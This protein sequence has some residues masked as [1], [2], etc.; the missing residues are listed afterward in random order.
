MVKRVTT[1]VLVEVRPTS[2]EARWVLADE[3]T[4]G[5]IVVAGAV[6]LQPVFVV[7]ASGVLEGVGAGGAFGGC[8]AE[9]VVG[10][11]GF[12]FPG[13]FTKSDSALLE[14]G[15]EVFCAGAR[16][17]GEYLVWSEPGEHV[18]GYGTSDGFLDHVGPVV[19][20]L[21]GSPAER[22]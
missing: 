9:G 4:V 10:I 11:G 21:G 20:L 7:F 17:P 2:A 19:E 22:L 12:D 5:W 18:G 15:Q 14:V 13:A 6:V 8:S 3:S 1:G 16:C